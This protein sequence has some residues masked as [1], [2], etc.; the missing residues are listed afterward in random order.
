M[1]TIVS[2][3]R[4]DDRHRIIGVTTRF[5]HIGQRPAERGRQPWERTTMTRTLSATLITVV[6]LAACGGERPAGGAADSAM[7]GTAAVAPAD[8]ARADTTANQATAAGA[9]TAAG[10]PS[11]A[12]T[13]PAA[14]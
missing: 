10:A 2:G 11:V 6:L 3:A 12:A 4:G 13:K 8:T 5:Y 14:P 1:G 7:S 9:D